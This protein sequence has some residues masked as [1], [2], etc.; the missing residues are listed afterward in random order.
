MTLLGI[1]MLKLIIFKSAGP[2]L[3]TLSG[4]VTLVRQFLNAEISISVI[5]FGMIALVS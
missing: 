3:V 5:L 1:S 4:I 2:I